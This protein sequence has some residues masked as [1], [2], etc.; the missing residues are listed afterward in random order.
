M[1]EK[2]KLTP[3]ERAEKFAEEY[4]KLCNKYNCQLTP[5]PAFTQEGRVVAQNQV[6]VND[7]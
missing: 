1:P 7:G 5:F 6:Q 2:K 3:Q 4:R